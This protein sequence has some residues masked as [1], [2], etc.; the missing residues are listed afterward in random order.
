MP[1]V[2]NHGGGLVA[3]ACRAEQWE[4]R[5]GALGVVP[6]LEHAADQPGTEVLDPGLDQTGQGLAG[7]A[8]D[9]HGRHEERRLPPKK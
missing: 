3:G 1:P 6:D 2:A 5:L 8:G 7:V 4:D 9:L